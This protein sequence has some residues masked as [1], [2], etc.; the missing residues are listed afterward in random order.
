MTTRAEESNSEVISEQQQ[1]L[2]E[3]A[4][5]YTAVRNQVDEAIRLAH[6]STNEV[7]LI[8]VSKTKPLSAILSARNAGAQYFGENYV[9]ELVAKHGELMA[10]HSNNSDKQAIEWHFIGHLQSNK[11]RMIAPFVTWIHSV[12]TVK[13]GIEISKQA[14]KYQHTINILV[15]INTSGE[16]SKSGCA[17][18]DAESIVRS[19][20][21]Q[22]N[23]AVRGLMTIPEA[24]ETAEEARP[25][26]QLLRK[27]RD[28]IAHYV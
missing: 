10:S 24:V 3:V 26:F 27:L 5:R 20:I 19:L 14:Q 28:D 4:T 6:R 13:L 22:P 16:E 18:E 7:R 11:V 1:W 2:E 9:Q 17:P 25:A 21:I 8:A 15:Q 12:D 23:I